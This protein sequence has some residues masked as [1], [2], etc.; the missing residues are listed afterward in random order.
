MS[1]RYGSHLKLI[2]SNAENNNNLVILLKKAKCF[3]QGQQHRAS[4]SAMSILLIVQYN[5]S[6][7]HRT[8]CVFTVVFD[9]LATHI[10]TLQGVVFRCMLGVSTHFRQNSRRRIRGNY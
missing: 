1:I 5:L 9:F 6:K 8:F 2:Q 4:E 3:L 7:C 10:F